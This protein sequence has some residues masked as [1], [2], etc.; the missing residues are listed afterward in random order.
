MF[1]NSGTVLKNTI[2]TNNSGNNANVAGTVDT[3]VNAS[4]GGHLRLFR[5][6]SDSRQC[7]K[8]VGGSFRA[9]A[10][11]AAWDKIGNLTDAETWKIFHD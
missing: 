11:A 2:V 9:E 6:V 4:G 8:W 3:V 10:R 5:A 7:Y 1:A